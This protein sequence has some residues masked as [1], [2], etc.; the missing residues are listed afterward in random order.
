MTFLLCNSFC[1][2][3]LKLK[4]Q[5]NDSRKHLLNFF[6]A[7]FAVLNLFTQTPFPISQKEN[8]GAS[9]IERNCLYVVILWSQWDIQ[10]VLPEHPCRCSYIDLPLQ[11]SGAC[12]GW[13][14]QNTFLTESI[15][16]SL[17]MYNTCAASQCCSYLSWQLCQAQVF[18]ALKSTL[19]TLS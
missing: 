8:Y 16:S 12:S 10:K 6:S 14:S 1:K 19:F 13:N 5:N 3:I 18:L 7:V 9:I 17:C 4:N 2:N 11:D 15:I